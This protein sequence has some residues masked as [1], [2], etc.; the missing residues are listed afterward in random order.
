MAEME[1]IGVVTDSISC[2]PPELIAK[3]HITVI[4]AANVYHEGKLYRDSVDLTLTDVDRILESSPHE[5]FTA[6][7]SP[8]QF[9]ETYN[10]LGK[11]YDAIIYVS[12]SSKL[13]TLCNDAR[14][15]RELFLKEN[16]NLRIEII[17]SH[18]A[19]AA[20]GFVALAAAK[21]AAEGKTIEEII[22]IASAIRKKVDLYYILDT[23]RYVYRTGRVPRSVSELGSRLN[24]K[25]L[26]T[27]RN[28]TPQIRGLVRNMERGIDTLTRIATQKM[29]NAPAHVGILHADVLKEAETLKQR[30][31]SE[32]NLVEIWISEFS[33]LM[34]YGTGKGVLGI[35]FYVEGAE[36]P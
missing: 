31:S 7:T 20:E 18:T 13:S 19:T 36:H 24:V 30:L 1:R 10:R 17:D 32:L 12:L 6:P 22:K 9:Q 11:E 21:A 29:G 35:G 15:A 25:P 28:G 34:V 2:L 27:I 8:G 23:I 4:P 16:P 33:P 14:L 5:F 3:Y 26:I